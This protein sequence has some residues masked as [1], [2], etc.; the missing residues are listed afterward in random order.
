MGNILYPLEALAPLSFLIILG[1]IIK[2]LKL[3]TKETTLAMNKVVFI[4]F[5]PALVFYN[6]YQADTEQIFN[7]PV[8]L[9]AVVFTVTIFILLLIIIPFIEKENSRR[10][11]L[12]QGIFRSNMVLLGIP[13]VT[14]LCGAAGAA[15]ITFIIS[16]VTPVYNVLAVICFEIFD[17]CKF[18]LKRVLMSILK[19]PLIIASALGV[20]ALLLKIQLPDICDKFISDVAK[21]ATPLALILLGGF[22]EIRH[23][24]LRLIIIGLLG[25]LILVPGLCITGAILLGFRGAE[26]ISL[27]AASCT[28]AAVSSFSMACELKGDTALASDLVIYGTAA[29]AVTIVGWIYLIQGLGFL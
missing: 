20:G 4:I 14:E 2:K 26:L 22:F 5:L 9:Y 3:I 25:R 7:G 24:E 8:I 23:S 11:V 1:F 18:S 28:P 29:S 6:L 19:N 13:I 16:V 21:I 27:M 10:S 15:T 12:I 17:K